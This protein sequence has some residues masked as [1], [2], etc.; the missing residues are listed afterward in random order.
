MAPLSVP[1]TYRVEAD[2]QSTVTHFQQDTCEAQAVI[3]SDWKN[4]VQHAS[5]LL[6][7]LCTWMQPEPEQETD[8]SPG[9]LPHGE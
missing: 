3:P 7:E 9:E 6:A 4:A 1:M 2:R 5:L 8:R